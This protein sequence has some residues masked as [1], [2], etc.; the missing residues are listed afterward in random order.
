MSGV[1]NQHIREVLARKY[2]RERAERLGIA[3]TAEELQQAA[4]DFRRLRGLD[5]ADAFQDW[6]KASDFTLEE[7]EASLETDIL[8]SKMPKAADE[9]E[10]ADQELDQVVGGSVSP[11]TAVT[12]YKVSPYTSTQQTMPTFNPYAT[13]NAVAGIRG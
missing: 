8:I 5:K 1:Y 2:A 3:V 7:F 6:L 9:D 12:S 4:D 13:E 11:Y 10:L